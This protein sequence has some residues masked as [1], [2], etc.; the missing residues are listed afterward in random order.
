MAKE[1]IDAIKKAEAAAAEGLSNA[2]ADAEKLVSDAR[3]EE[4]A[5][6]DA[7]VKKPVMRLPQR[8]QMHRLLQTGKSA[9]RKRK[10]KKQRLH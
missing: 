9:K 6:Y 1:I 5:Y 7:E 8:C 3:N 4:K 10:P 2:K